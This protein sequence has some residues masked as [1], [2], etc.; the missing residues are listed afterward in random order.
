VWSDAHGAAQSTYKATNDLFL[1]VDALIDCPCWY[2]N[3]FDPATGFS[4]ENVSQEESVNNVEQII[5]P[6]GR[7]TTGSPIRVSVVAR[8]LM[9]DGIVPDG[10]V[11]RQ[12]FA[13]LVDNAH[14]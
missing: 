9:A 5:I 13:V 8:N 7:L 11:L 2:G 1:S 12:D 14:Q 10:G 4:K 3:T 6:A